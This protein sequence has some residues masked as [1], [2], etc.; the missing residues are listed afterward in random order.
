MIGC[1]FV[2]FMETSVIPQAP[3]TQPSSRGPD[4]VALAGVKALDER[5]SAQQSRI[6]ALEAENAEL[7]QRLERLEKLLSEERPGTQNHRD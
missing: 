2:A 4:G 7:R 3:A 1:F 6:E 5:T